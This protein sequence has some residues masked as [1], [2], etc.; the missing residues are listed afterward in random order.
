[1]HS[2]SLVIFISLLSMFFSCTEKSA[3]QKEELISHV[4]SG[5]HGIVAAGKKP[6]VAAGLEVLREGGNAMDAAVAV[7][8]AETITEYG[9]FCI[10][11]EAAVLIYDNVHKQVK[12]LSG[13]GT[14]PMD[15]TA[16]KWYYEHGI[17]AGDIKAA[18]VPAI[19]DLCVT[20]L[21]NYGTM[22]F[23]QTVAP[24]RRLLQS[25]EKKWYAD[26]DRT[27]GK[28]V[29]AEKETNGTREE[30]LQAVADRFYRGDIADS[31]V[32]W[33]HLNGGFLTNTDLAKYHT[34][35]E[36]ATEADFLGYQVYK[37][38]PWTQGPM[39]L[40]SLR[41]LERFNFDS[42]GYMSS[43][44]IHLITE[45][46]KL[47]FADRDQYYGDPAF[48]RVPL[49]RLLSQSYT[50]IRVPLIDMNKT[51]QKARPGDPYHMKQVLKET[52]F[53]EGVKG[54]TTCI[55]ADRWGNVAVITPSGWGSH[56]GTGGNTG[57][58]PS[59]R[60][61]SFNILKGH[62]NCIEPGKRPRITLT[63][64]LVLKDGDPVL[65]IS[66]EGGDVQE[67][68]SL[69]ILLSILE[70]D[71]MPEEAVTVVRFAT[72]LQQ[73]S[74]NPIKDRNSAY[75]GKIHLMINKNVDS[76]VVQELEARGHLIRFTD[77][78]I[79]SP[80]VIFIDPSTGYCSGATDPGI[81]HFTGA[82]E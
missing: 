75:P 46:L 30:K 77:Q 9:D 6:S 5:D 14:A 63:P 56:A 28:M 18:P 45:S 72:D 67:Q 3:R 37:C 65:A 2:H 43:D 31:L 34:I 12:A 7:V 44:Y 55:V 20:L 62:P 53:G 23:E 40:Q 68:T 15:T 54:T 22:S 1:M 70:Y 82:L 35:I 41:L 39:L 16:I 19:P 79:G 66:V 64:T 17:P 42:L 52:D 29:D 60:L 36:D 26:Q 27:F 80:A 47:A 11:G 21:K 51:S 58:T 74:F 78:P 33:Y 13:Q 10:G 4:A 61:I 24:A 48:T 8:L 57:I 69:E 81:P 25:N 73:D 59:T 32:A 71:K 38:G 76:T 49:Y 50:D